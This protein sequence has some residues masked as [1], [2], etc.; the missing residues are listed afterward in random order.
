MIPITENIPN[1]SES[2]GSRSLNN[3]EDLT[4]PID[5]SL[6]TRKKNMIAEIDEPTTLQIDLAIKDESDLDKLCGYIEKRTRIMIKVECGDCGKSLHLQD[7]GEKGAQGS[8]RLPDE[9]AG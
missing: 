4:L 7:H 6:M 3:T 1:W 5:E 2:I 8:L 9:Q